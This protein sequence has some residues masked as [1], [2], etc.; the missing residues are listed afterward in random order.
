VLPARSK[1]GSGTYN[2]SGSPLIQSVTE[3]FSPTALS[4]PGR[5]VNIMRSPGAIARASFTDSNRSFQLDMVDPWTFIGLPKLWGCTSHLLTHG[6]SV[7]LSAAAS[8][9]S[10][11]DSL[12]PDCLAARW[13]CNAGPLRA[14]CRDSSQRR[15]VERGTGSWP[16]HITIFGGLAPFIATWLIAHTHNP[17][18]SAWYLSAA[19][20]ISVGC[21][22]G[23]SRAK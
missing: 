18:S 4:L 17:S 5:I 11:T 7:P 14:C 13:N 10:D 2:R 12:R 21:M 19:A 20:A 15:T 6:A 22:I 23:A 8:Q 16:K 1:T 3:M 9:R